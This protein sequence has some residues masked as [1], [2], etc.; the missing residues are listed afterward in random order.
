LARGRPRRRFTRGSYSLA[1]S[2]ERRSPLAAEEGANYM[3]GRA[4]GIADPRAPRVVEAGAA[5]DTGA[6][7][8]PSGLG[9]GTGEDLAYGCV[10][11]FEYPSRNDHTAGLR[12]TADV[13]IG[14]APH[15]E[16]GAEKGAAADLT[17]GCVDWFHYV[18]G[19]SDGADR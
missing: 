14:G 6:S 19:E 16:A 18:Y 17:H 7:R 8:T 11:W 3:N 15:R 10:D 9:Q 1:R 2:D 13:D 4:P 5:A 12:C